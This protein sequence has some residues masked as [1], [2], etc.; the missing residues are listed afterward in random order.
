PAQAVDLRLRPVGNVGEGARLDLAVLAIALAQE[1]GWRRIAV[2]D[3]RDVHDQLESRRPGAVNNHITCLQIRR[4]SP[5]S[6]TNPHLPAKRNSE[7]RARI[8][9]KLPRPR[10]T[11][12]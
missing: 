5:Q 9:A 8:I 1:H 12:T 2:R 3:A 10:V 6:R 7:V 11:F 4:K